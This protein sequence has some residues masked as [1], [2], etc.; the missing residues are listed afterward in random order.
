MDYKDI[1]GNTSAQAVNE[2]SDLV[3]SDITPDKDR[4]IE[5]E[6]EKERRRQQR[7]DALNR[8]F[9]HVDTQRQRQ[10]YLNRNAELVNET[11]E[12]DD[13]VMD[14]DDAEIVA[15]L[16]EA[17]REAY[18]EQKRAEEEQMRR[19]VRKLGISRKIQ[20]V[21]IVTSAEERKRG[22]RQMAVEVVDTMINHTLPPNKRFVT[23]PLGTFEEEKVI[24]SK[25]E[26]RKV[27][28]G[29]S[30]DS[31]DYQ[32]VPTPKDASNLLKSQGYRP[33]SRQPAGD[34]YYV[35][36]NADGDQRRCYFY[37]NYC[38]VQ[39]RKE[40]I[41]D[42]DYD[43]V[44]Q[45]TQKAV[46]PE[47]MQDTD[48]ELNE[49]IAR[50]KA[51]VYPYYASISQPEQGNAS[52]IPKSKLNAFFYVCACL[53]SMSSLYPLHY[54]RL[55]QLDTVTKIFEFITSEDFSPEFTVHDLFNCNILFNLPTGS[56]KTFA[57]LML[58]L[59]SLHDD[60]SGHC[61]LQSRMSS[62][63]FWGTYS[64]TLV[65]QCLMDFM[66]VFSS[67]AFGYIYPHKTAIR[68]SELVTI[69][70]GTTRPHPA[71]AYIILGTYEHIDIF[72]RESILKPA[73]GDFSSSKDPIPVVVNTTLVVV[74][75]IHSIDDA[76]SS[77]GVRIDDFLIVARNFGIP[78][79]TLT[80]TAS[81]ELKQRLRSAF[82]IMEIDVK[83][84]K[85]R[86]H[87]TEIYFMRVKGKDKPFD[88][89]TCE[90]S[91]STLMLLKLAYFRSY[92]P[93]TQADDGN[94]SR[95]IVYMN[96]TDYVE[97][98]YGYFVG[99]VY[100]IT[101]RFDDNLQRILKEETKIQSQSITFLNPDLALEGY[102]EARRNFSANPKLNITSAHHILIAGL[103]AGI[104]LDHSKLYLASD[105]MTRNSYQKSYKNS[106]AQDIR[107]NILEITNLREA[108]VRIVFCTSIIMTGV[109]IYQCRDMYIDNSSVGY[110]NNE[111][112]YQ[113]IGRVGRYM[114]SRVYLFTET[115]EGQHLMRHKDERSYVMLNSELFQRIFRILLFQKRK[116]EKSNLFSKLDDMMAERK[117]PG[118]TGNIRGYYE[119][120]ISSAKVSQDPKFNEY[121]SIDLFKTSN[122]K[123]VFSVYESSKQNEKLDPLAYS[124]AINFFTPE[125]ITLLG[126]EVSQ[127]LRDRKVYVSSLLFLPFTWYF[128]YL[129]N[130][131]SKLK[132]KACDPQLPDF[133]NDNVVISSIKRSRQDT[134]S[135]R[136]IA[137]A[138]EAATR[139]NSTEK[140]DKNLFARF[141]I[142]AMDIL[143]SI[144]VSPEDFYNEYNTVVFEIFKKMYAYTFVFGKILLEIENNIGDKDE[145]MSNIITDIAMYISNI[146]NAFQAISNSCT[147]S[148]E[149]AIT[150]FKDNKSMPIRG[151]VVFK[152]LLERDTD[153]SIESYVKYFIEPIRKLS[154]DGRSVYEHWDLTSFLVVCRIKNNLKLQSL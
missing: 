139:V 132:K 131:I 41:T 30:V 15:G 133:A 42:D 117:V 43:I 82:D 51:V 147:K 138:L 120:I 61:Q 109:N 125:I 84:N 150:Q 21:H 140:F 112:F 31:F 58:S 65:D 40:D 36:G 56:G 152:Y 39:R 153:I 71:K 104:V 1:G 37:T 46:K 9:E 28:L 75:E 89:E 25:T 34:G 146:R 23:A 5:S 32:K 22:L 54:L 19:L 91:T 141:N 93:W 154:D 113:L 12:K 79:V 80:G 126:E 108:P 48:D 26:K 148:L 130:N 4:V 62:K 24:V 33:V 99:L 151:N 67:V 53:A 11:S 98:A 144:F 60:F 59:I 6:S 145:K 116:E 123:M 50:L 95:S 76:E 2:Y 110:L 137:N 57:G 69:G 10:L 14:E 127:H 27:Y 81:A 128:R 114:S 92:M 124:L 20:D 72:Y 49:A 44:E 149:S 45:V 35:F 66:N 86:P 8:A 83:G 143:K 7:A 85:A 38:L 119:T 94:K 64:K 122:L 16:S 111:S 55:W 118:Y 107:K 74:D 87:P 101:P 106:I 142:L 29:T 103:L 129:I 97:K 88:P 63:V 47:T 105:V 3:G 135:Y 100:S 52:Q 73:A 96:Y 77:R 134:A 90:L 115:K 78:I 13:V 17:D 68:T 121:T 70:A 136:K 18:L 102:N